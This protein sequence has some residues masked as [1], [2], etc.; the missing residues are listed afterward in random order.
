MT[1]NSSIF[2]ADSKTHL[3]IV[4]VSLIASIAVVVVGISARPLPPETTAARI[5]TPIKIGPSML[6]TSQ[7]TTQI[8]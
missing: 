6:A 4:V 3:K 5:Q 2:T 7:Q 1:N 8:R